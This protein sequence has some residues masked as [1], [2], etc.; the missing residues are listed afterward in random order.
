MVAVR[1]YRE[2]STMFGMRRVRWANIDK[3]LRDICERYGES[4]M[5]AFITAPAGPQARDLQEI[6]KQPTKIQAVAEWLTERGDIRINAEWRLELV[7][8]ALFGCAIVA[9]VVGILALFH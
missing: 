2:G 4:V 1:I 9:I 3:D 6:Y 5:Q 7:Q 8:W